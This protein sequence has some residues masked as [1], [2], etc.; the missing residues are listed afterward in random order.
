MPAPACRLR[1]LL[2]PILAAAALWFAAL[3]GA[4]AA[5]C[6]DVTFATLW[7]LNAVRSRQGLPPLRLDTR[8]SRAA[9]R[10]SRDMVVRR[11]FAH[12]SITGAHF[13]RRIAATGWTRGRG[14]ARPT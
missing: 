4:A 13:S 5:W 2:V 11:Y 6:G 3:P 1:R 12:E 7:S 14:R 8:L 10:H 9:R